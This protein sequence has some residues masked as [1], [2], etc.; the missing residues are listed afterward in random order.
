LRD[1]VPIHDVA[2]RFVD[3]V[4][5]LVDGDPLRGARH[6]R[7]RKTTIVEVAL[8]LVAGLVTQGD[9]R[10]ELHDSVQQRRRLG[11][12]EIAGVD[13]LHV[14]RDFFPVDAAAGHRCNADDLD[15][16]QSLLRE[17]NPGQNG[18]GQQKRAFQRFELGQRNPPS[19]FRPRYS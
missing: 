17:R 9:K 4:A 5:V 1:Q 19:H 18:T 2:E 3:P 10:H 14:G 7:G 13:R 8:E 6:R 16:L 11:R 12:N 15:R